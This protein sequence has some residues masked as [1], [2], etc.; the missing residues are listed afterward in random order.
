MALATRRFSAPAMKPKEVDFGERV[1]A[2]AA[3]GA[4]IRPGRG[5]SLRYSI[6][7]GPSAKIVAKI[8]AGR[9]RKAEAGGWFR[10][11]ETQTEI[12]PDLGF[13]TGAIE[14]DFQLCFWLRKLLQIRMIRRVDSAISALVV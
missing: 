6:T 7:S 5:I 4:S 9:R 10:R 8:V 11:L 3:G 12:L 14:S 13:G 1:P 2:C